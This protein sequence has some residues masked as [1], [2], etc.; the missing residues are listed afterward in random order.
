MIVRAVPCVGVL[1]AALTSWNCAPCVARVANRND[2]SHPGASQSMSISRFRLLAESQA[3]LADIPVDLV[4]AVIKVESDYDPTR[5]GSVGEIGL[6]QIRPA[7]AAML[8]FHGSL[9]ELAD[10]ATNIR[11][12]TTYLAQAWRLT[13]GDV[14]RTLMKYR[15]GHGQEQMSQLS[16]TYC[17]HALAHLAAIAS[18]L[19]ADV[20]LPTAQVATPQIHDH[21]ITTRTSFAV[22]PRHGEAFWRAEEARVRTITARLHAKWRLMAQR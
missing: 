2:V 4:D 13:H 6:M 9:T 22:A 19:A 1:L 3:R 20:A 16:V 7:T 8:G 18:P 17:S 14:C 15:A 5:I 21:A 12:G 10:P 11:Y